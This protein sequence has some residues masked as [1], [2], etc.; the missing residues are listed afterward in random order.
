MYNMN[1]VT[2]ESVVQKRN[3]LIQAKQQQLKAIAM[4]NQAL[5]AQQQA[6]RAQQQQQ[7]VVEEPVAEEQ[8]V[9]PVKKISRFKFV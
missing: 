5:R 1:F 2:P 9:V 4:R 6:L 3:M 7:Q 8:V